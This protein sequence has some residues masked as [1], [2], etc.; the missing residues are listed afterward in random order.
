METTEA[1]IDNSP[2]SLQMFRWIRANLSQ[3][4]RNAILEFLL[5]PHVRSLRTRAALGQGRTERIS[6]ILETWPISDDG[7]GIPSVIGIY[8][9][10]GWQPD[11]ETDLAYVGQ[12]AKVKAKNGNRG[13]RSRSIVHFGR[14]MKC[15]LFLRPDETTR[16]GRKTSDPDILWAHQRLASPTVASIELAV[17]SVFPFPCSAV[18]NGNIH[19]NY[20][21]SLAEAIDVLFLKSL[22]LENND[23]CRE[24][25]LATEQ[26]IRPSN[27][28]QWRFEGLNRALPSKQRV[29]FGAPLLALYWSPDEIAV[30]LE[31]FEQ[32]KSEIYAWNKID[33]DLISRLLNTR[34][35]VKSIARIRVMYRTL[36]EIPNSGLSSIRASFWEANWAMI[37][38][39]KQILEEKQLVH[40][41]KDENDLF[42]HIPYLEDGLDTSRQV[43]A[44]NRFIGR[45]RDFPDGFLL[46]FLPRNLSCLLQRGVWD[47]ITSEYS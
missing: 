34:G 19:Y 23:I 6:S 25:R 26:V 41:P 4:S 42:F 14:I 33:W 44:L 43:Y 39:F 37:Y 22:K 8:A 2:F 27:L 5:H 31:V 36:S 24:Y 40:P 1:S 20:L 9:L 15:K 47:K 32:H 11:D 38:H 7:E 12:S 28:P 35:V 17:L 30:F 3:E 45:T 29:R 16:S 10:F 18:G 46:D 21:L 13:I